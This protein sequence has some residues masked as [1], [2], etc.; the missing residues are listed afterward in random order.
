[1]RKSAVCVVIAIL[2]ILLVIAS[3]IA[4]SDADDSASSEQPVFGEYIIEM[5]GPIE[6]GDPDKTTTTPIPTDRVS[7]A[8]KN[9]QGEIVSKYSLNCILDDNASS[10]TV[11]K[12]TLKLTESYN[13][14]VVIIPDKLVHSA[15]TVDGVPCEHKGE[16]YTCSKVNSLALGDSVET[17]IVKG[18]PE[19]GSVSGGNYSNFITA[20]SLKTLIIE[21]NPTYCL[22]GLALVLGSGVKTLKE[23]HYLSSVE[24]LP[25]IWNSPSA[26]SSLDVYLTS[27][28]KTKIPANLLAP[29]RKASSDSYS[30]VNLHFS[31]GS[32]T[33]ASFDGTMLK[34]TTKT[35]FI[36][37]ADSQYWTDYLRTS[38][39]AQDVSLNESG[40][41]LMDVTGYPSH[42]I[43]YTN[44][45]GGS[46]S[47]VAEAA[48][49]QTVSIVVTPD[50][51]YMLKDLKYTCAGVSNAIRDDGGYSF[52]MPDGDVQLVAVFEKCIPIIESKQTVSGSRICIDIDLNGMPSD[53]KAPSSI[54]V[55]VRYAGGNA[56][57][58]S[59]GTF[60]IP[61]YSDSYSASYETSITSQS[62]TSYLIQVFAA[63]GT[64][65]NQKEVLISG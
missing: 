35:N 36:I 28:E 49:G 63:D 27:S 32:L 17:L 40:Y 14:S 61:S 24:T 11:V 50:D 8:V 51:G 22:G 15:H 3:P 18:S 26:A 44:Y 54:S 13:N 60:T 43:N 19:L 16:T 4:G 59:K 42:K 48:K 5:D 6:K 46:I 62:P 25:Q 7:F 41:S 29:H 31:K 2:G 12:N 23:V 56:D 53:G 38:S 10:F 37:D 45:D 57:M 30:T 39:V 1:M 55:F 20:G 33:P 34:K 58:F 65:L 52:T 64:C 47:S 21:G 9:K